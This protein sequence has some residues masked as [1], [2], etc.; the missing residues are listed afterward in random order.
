MFGVGQ[1]ALEKLLSTPSAAH[2][3]FRR[4]PILPTELERTCQA[5]SNEVFNQSFM[6]A[7]SRRNRLQ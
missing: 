4:I 3:S 7:D 2:H 1:G 5:R 6:A